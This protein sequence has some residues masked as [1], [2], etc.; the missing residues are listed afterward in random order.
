M[1]YDE[2]DKIGQRYGTDKSS[3]INNYLFFYHR[4]FSGLRGKSDLRLLE[5]GVHEGASLKMWEEYFPHAEIIVGMDVNPLAKC[6]EGGR[7]VVELGDQSDPERLAFI[8][9]QHG[10][11]DIV[12]DDGSHIW[13]H[14]VTSLRNLFEYV[15]PGGFYVLE[16][17]ATSFGG[18]VAAYRGVT[19]I[20]PPVS[21][22]TQLATYVTGGEHCSYSNEQDTFLRL[23]ASQITSVCFHRF[24]AIIERKA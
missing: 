8:G 24:T 12:L 5:I 11:F 17:L 19:G 15:K 16:D 23:A 18:Y 2:L 22:V 6:F 3:L 20:A 10:P 1:S 14:Q 7:I 9:H 21:Y 4:Y 13:D